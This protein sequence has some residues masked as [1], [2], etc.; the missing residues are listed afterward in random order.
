MLHLIVA[1]RHS[2][3]AGRRSIVAGRRSIVAGRHSIVAGRHSIVAGR[4]SISLR[5][6]GLREHGQAGHGANE[7][8]NR[9]PHLRTLPNEQAWTD[10]SGGPSGSPTA[11][12]KNG[13]NRRR[14]QS[15]LHRTGAEG[16]LQVAGARL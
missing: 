2:I 15:P 1:G 13:S 5:R 4:H 3:V 6:R 9:L 10:S 8:C 16:V 11:H 14:G 12:H 7:H